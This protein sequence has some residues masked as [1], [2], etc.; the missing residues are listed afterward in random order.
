MNKLKWKILGIYEDLSYYILGLPRFLFVWKDNK[1][2]SLL[3]FFDNNVKKRP[4]DIAFIF[5]G[6]EITWKEANEQTN[7]YAGFLKSQKINKG[8]CFAILMDNS[9]DFLMLLLASFRVGSLAALI[10]TTVSGEGLKHVI[11]ISDVKLITAGA[12]HLEKLSSALGDSDLKNIPIFGMEDNEKIP[13]QVEDIKKLSKQFSTFI[14]YQPIMKD[15]AAYIFTSG[16]TGLPKAALVDHA[17]LVKGSFAGHFL[18]FNFNKNDRLYMT[19]PLY[20]STGLILGW[21][22]SL[23]SGCPNVIKSKFSASDFW[24]DVKKYNVNK[25]IYVG[26]LCRYLMNLP[27]SDGDKDNPITQISGNGLRPDIWESFQK[28]FNISKIV[29]IYGATEA[30][31]MTINSFG[32][33]GM[34]GRKRSDSTIIHCNKD[35][36]SPILNDEGF[37]TKVSE[38]ETGLYIQKIS[39]SAK[40]Q[41]YLDAQASN[42]KILQNVFKTGDQYF[43]TG[44]LITLHDNN[45]LSFADRVGDT[46]RWKSENVS[47]M[48]VAAILNNASGVMDCNVYGVQ[49]DSAEGKAGMAAMNVSDEFSFISFIEH[50][51]KNLNT[52]QKPYF[53]RL[54]KE[55]QTTGTFKHQKEDLKK[56]GFNPSLIKDKLYFLQKNNYVEIDQAL[57]CLLYTSPS[58]RDI[59]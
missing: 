23:R 41:G 33:S 51:N 6:D 28:R 59:R 3:N 8:D 42:K 48:E 22:A 45:W 31:G 18:C 44:D 34:I 37:C 50:V 56:Q 17:K 47:T 24:N 52:F 54:T 4:N 58:P 30:V 32:R 57:Y 14:P 9:P 29:E 5:E 53:L 49:V 43:N 13:D 25:F 27:P 20:H 11:G 16:T 40:F 19:L 26:E 36:G 1:K 2:L 21:A 46:Y 10:N 38:G 12:S 15:V 55:M 7:K 39:S 35:D